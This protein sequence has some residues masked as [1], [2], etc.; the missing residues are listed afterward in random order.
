MAEIVRIK[1]TGEICTVVGA[2]IHAETGAE[3]LDLQPV[4]RNQHRFVLRADIAAATMD[5]MAHDVAVTLMRAVS[6]IKRTVYP[7]CNDATLEALISIRAVLDE[8]VG[9]GQ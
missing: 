3:L 5:D 1:T 4:G 8:L 2:Y 9:E 6:E 7:D